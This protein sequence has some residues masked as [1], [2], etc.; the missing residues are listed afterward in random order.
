MLGDLVDWISNGVEFIVKGFIIFV[1]AL[2]AIVL[3]GTYAPVL[4]IPLIAILIFLLFRN[5]NICENYD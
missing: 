2:V 5:R 4:Y 3:I 1:V